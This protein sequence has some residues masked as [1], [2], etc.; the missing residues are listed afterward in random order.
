[1]ICFRFH[2]RVHELFD[3]GY[4]EFMIIDPYYIDLFDFWWETV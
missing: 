3:Q 2:A 4:G 1:M